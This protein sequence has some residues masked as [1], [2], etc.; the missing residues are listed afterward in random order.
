MFKHI[1]LPIDDSPASR[2]AVRKAIAFAAEI[3]ARI[4]GYHAVPKDA[5]GVYGEGYSFSTAR[6]S[7]EMKRQARHSRSAERAAAEA[8]STGVRYR[9]VVGE[10]SSPEEGI[11]SAARARKCDIILIGTHG[12]RGLARLALGSVAEQ[13]IRQATIPVLVVR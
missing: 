11:L 12:R 2:K 3:G 4:T 1:L 6:Q 7:G 10:A 5:G 8:R 9:T 13:V